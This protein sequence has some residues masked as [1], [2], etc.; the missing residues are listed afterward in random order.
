MRP[1]SSTLRALALRVLPVVVMSTT[2]SAL[3]EAGADL[4][5]PVRLDDAVAGDVAVGEV[6]S[7]QVDVFGG[8]PEPSAVAVAEVGGDVA[9][10]G[11][12]GDVDP[13]V[14]DRDD[15]FGFAE[16]EGLCEDHLVGAVLGF[17]VDEVG[18]GDAEIDRA[19]DQLSGDFARG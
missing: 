14:G 17:L 4:V 15:D 11:H 19:A 8:H 7:R 13:A 3:P 5:A 12:L 9:E 16:T 10:V 2:R 1:S 18:A 6:F